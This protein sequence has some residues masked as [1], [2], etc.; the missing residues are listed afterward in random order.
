MTQFLTV[1]DAGS[2]LIGAGLTKIDADFTTGLIL[3]GAG[4]VLKVLVAVLQKFDIPVSMA[5]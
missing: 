1:G 3:V 4:V 5:K 2:L